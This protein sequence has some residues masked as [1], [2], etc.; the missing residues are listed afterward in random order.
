MAA[1]AFETIIKYLLIFIYLLRFFKSIVNLFG[2]YDVYFS[3][4]YYLIDDKFKQIY[5]FAFLF[6]QNF[7]KVS[8]VYQPQI[9]QKLIN[10]N[11]INQ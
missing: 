7:S 8:S 4:R 5:N 1:L 9:E 11:F 6:V 2:K 10:S 3:V